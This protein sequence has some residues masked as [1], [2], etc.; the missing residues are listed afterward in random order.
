M[1]NI[2][3]VIINFAHAGPIGIEEEDKKAFLPTM[4]PFLFPTCL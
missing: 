1:V 3:L 4:D 2:I